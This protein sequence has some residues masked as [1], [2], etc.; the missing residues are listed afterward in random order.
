MRRRFLFPLVTLAA[1]LAVIAAACG[2]GDEATPIKGVPKPTKVPATDTSTVVPTVAPTVVPTVAPTLAPTVA[3]TDTTTP[4]PTSPPTDGSV[5]NLQVS[6]EGDE[7]LFD[8]SEFKANVGDQVVLVFDN[9]AETKQHNWVLVKAGTKDDV[10]ARGAAFPVDNY[11][12][13]D[14]SDIIAHTNLLDPGEKG[15][16]RFTAPSPGT[17]QFVCTFPLHND[18]MF[19]D[20][21]VT[22]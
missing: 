7:E 22:Q 10:A 6:V 5:V 3:P 16:V 19:G 17:Y 4:A 9:A 12:D 18:T 2:G 11:V 13:P 8:I 21:E 15:E 20:F 1:S 14:D